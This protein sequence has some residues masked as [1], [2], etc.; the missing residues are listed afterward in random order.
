MGPLRPGY[1]R[2]LSNPEDQ[3]DPKYDR[4]DQKRVEIILDPLTDYAERLLL[5]PEN[6]EQLRTQLNRRRTEL[7]R[8]QNNLLM[9]VMDNVDPPE[10]V[11]EKARE[12]Q[13]RLD[14]L[15][16]AAVA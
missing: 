5:T 14:D 3:K 13:S 6:I 7:K 9:L 16:F 11:S 10:I 12:I 15:F 1:E 2:Y 8:Q 4:I